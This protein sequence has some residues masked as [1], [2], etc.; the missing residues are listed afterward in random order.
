MLAPSALTG[1]VSEGQRFFTTFLQCRS[2]RARLKGNKPPYP[3]VFGTFL[4]PPRL[5]KPHACSQA[6]KKNQLSFG[7]LIYFNT[8]VKPCGNAFELLCCYLRNLHERLGAVFIPNLPT[9]AA[10]L[11]TSG[12]ALNTPQSWHPSLKPS[13]DLGLQ[14]LGIKIAK[15]SK[16]D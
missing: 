10:R 2:A 11:S 7:I 1:M 12:C 16:T 5:H 6:K 15:F 9:C 13:Q 3:A 4:S 8:Q 14:Q